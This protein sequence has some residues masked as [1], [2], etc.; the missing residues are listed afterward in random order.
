MT[1]TF[2]ADTHTYKVG[3]ETIP[4]VTQVLKELGLTRSYDGV[5]DFYRMRGTAVHKAIELHLRGTLDEQSVDPV[6]LPY[7]VAFKRFLQDRGDEFESELPLYSQSLGCAGTIDLVQHID[8]S[9][10]I[11]YDA[12]CT[13]S[14]DPGAELQLCAYQLLFEQNSQKKV[15]GKFPLQLRKDGSFVPPE[16]FKKWSDR[17]PK[18]WESA[19][20]LY[21]WKKRRP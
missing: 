15:R 20:E 21:R 13:E 9:S 17:D 3:V 1:L 4:S 11:I 10:V 12:K 8:D 16:K 6:C 18:I 7:F 5:D 19:M 14:V 2:D